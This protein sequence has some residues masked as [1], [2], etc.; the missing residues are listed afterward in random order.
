MMINPVCPNCGSDDIQ[1]TDKF[2]GTVMEPSEAILDF[3]CSE[4]ECLFQIIDAPIDT[5]VVSLD[6]DN[7]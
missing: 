1:T 3:E 4:C 2:D 7:E 6:D 5:R